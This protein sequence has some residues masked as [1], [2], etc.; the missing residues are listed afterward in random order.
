MRVDNSYEGDGRLKKTLDGKSYDTETARAVG[1][2]KYTGN[3]GGVTE[4]LYFTKSGRYFLYI[5]GNPLGVYRR[6]GGNEE[7][8]PLSLEEAKEWLESYLTV[9][10]YNRW[11]GV[12]EPTDANERERFT[13]NLSPACKV[14]LR[15]IKETT[16]KTYS[17]IIEWLVSEYEMEND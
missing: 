10:E 6:R 7:I 4:T 13:T 3:V 8:A 12:V 1:T 2:R 5:E 16:G 15:Q 11:F 17:E 14:K 9:D